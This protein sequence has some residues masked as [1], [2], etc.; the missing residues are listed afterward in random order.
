MRMESAAAAKRTTTRMRPHRTEPHEGTYI[1]RMYD[2]L[3]QSKGQPIETSLSM[4]E[5]RPGVAAQ[6]IEYLRDFY[7]L[8]IRKIQQGRWVLA[9]EWF[10]CEYRDYI[11]EHLERK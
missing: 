10:G 4:F 11:S 3:K 7:G 8:D 1:R 6:A 5:G 9:G 2:L